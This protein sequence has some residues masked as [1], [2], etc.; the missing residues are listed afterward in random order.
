MILMG[1]KDNMVLD[2]MVYGQNGKD[3][4]VYG[5][6]GIGKNGSDKRVRTKW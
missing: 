4:T 2:K 3:K 1:S 5:Q 6:S